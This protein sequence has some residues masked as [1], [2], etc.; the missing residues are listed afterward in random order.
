MIQSIFHSLVIG[1]LIATVWGQT[2]ETLRNFT[3]DG[4]DFTMMHIDHGTMD[5]DFSG[6]GEIVTRG[7]IM[8]KKFSNR[9]GTDYYVH[10][11]WGAGH[12]WPAG[13]EL[14]LSFVSREPWVLLSKDQSVTFNE[15]MEILHE[16]VEKVQPDYQVIPMLE[17]SFLDCFPAPSTF[18][19]CS[20]ETQSGTIH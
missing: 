8:D 10:T 16:Q 13:E 18:L 2:L 5:D 3:K 7:P 1:L 4:K 20:E 17:L 12:K 19:D 11:A 14:D 15:A 9:R 6:I